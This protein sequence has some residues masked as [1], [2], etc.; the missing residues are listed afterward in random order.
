M[1]TTIA[2]FRHQY[3]FGALDTYVYTI[4]NAGTKRV[5]VRITDHPNV[6]GLTCVIKQNSSTLTTVTGGSQTGRLEANAQANFAAN[7]TFS[8]VVTSSAANDS[9]GNRVRGTIDIEGLTD[10]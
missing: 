7:D 3:L 2:N 4:V 8:V 6:G 10:Q 1:S 9:L 5:T